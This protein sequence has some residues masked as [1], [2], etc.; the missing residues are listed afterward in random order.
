M[1]GADVIQSLPH[2]NNGTRIP[3]FECVPLEAQA[4]V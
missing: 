4:P 2:L 1:S 3:E